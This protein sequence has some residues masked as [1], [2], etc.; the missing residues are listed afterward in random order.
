[1]SSNN[2][3]DNNF[4]VTT[5]PSAYRDAINERVCLKI[6]NEFK[7]QPQKQCESGS[8]EWDLYPQLIRKIENEGSPNDVEELHKIERTL[9][10]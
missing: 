7:G 4:D 1:M 6:N 2:T 10:K 3:D 5:N 8:N 9:S